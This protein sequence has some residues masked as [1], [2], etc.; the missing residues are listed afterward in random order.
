[1]VLA[2][3]SSTYP[4]TAAATSIIASSRCSGGEDRVISTYI[5][6]TFFTYLIPHILFHV[7]P[8]FHNFEDRILLRRPLKKIIVLGACTPL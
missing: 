5:T 4:I 6:N 3:T 2:V 7:A 1:M 8:H